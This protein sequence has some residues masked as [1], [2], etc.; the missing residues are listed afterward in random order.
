MTR[1]VFALLVGIDAYRPPIN[2]LWGSRNDTRAL[3]QYLKVR[4]GD[5]L[6]VRT[7]YDEEATRDAL[8]AAF[9]DHLGQ[10]GRGDVAL[11]AYAGHGSEEPAPPA[12]L[13]LEPTGRIQTLILHD[14]GRRVGGKLQRAF[15]DKEL[16]VLLAELADRGPHV[17]VILDCCNSGGGT[18]DPFVGIRSW[19]P[20]AAT[21]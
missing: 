20:D 11:F 17:A 5:E 6:T 21:A 9:R 3:E 13:H 1:R 18:R 8:V 16:A 15:A 12:V 14:C 7:L 4:V 2:P 19:L 10:A